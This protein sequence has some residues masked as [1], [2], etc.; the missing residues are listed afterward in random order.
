MKITNP[1][2]TIIDYGDMGLLERIELAGRLCYKSEDKIAPGTAK[3]FVDGCLKKKH[4]SVL[5]MA[6]IT[7]QYPIEY[8][9]PISKYCAISYFGIDIIVTCSLRVL[10]DSKCDFLL[11]QLPI[12]V[13]VGYKPSTIKVTLDPE[14]G[15]TP[16]WKKHVHKAVRFIVDRSC[17]HELVRHRPIQIL[18]ESQRY[19]RYGD[20]EVIKPLYY[21]EGTYEYGLWLESMLHAEDT[22]NKLLNKSSPQAA[23]KVLPNSTKTELI[24]LASI[25]QWEHMFKLRTSPGADPTMREVMVPLEEEFKGRGLIC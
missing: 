7:F 22:Y 4:M 10:V 16:D 19:V 18:Q 15:F 12:G 9:H 24:I 14:P 17:S 20:L 23:R 13:D 3:P 21:P 25:E 1:S 8:G 11:K 6:M 5:E 2:A